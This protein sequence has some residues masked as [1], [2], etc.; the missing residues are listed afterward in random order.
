MTDF[1]PVSPDFKSTVLANLLYLSTTSA[2]GLNA[3]T[4]SV[5]QQEATSRFVSRL[6]ADGGDSAYVPTTTFYSGFFDE[7]V[8]P[9]Q[10]TIASAFLNDARGVGVLNNEVQVR[11]GGRP[12]GPFYGHAGVLFNPLTYALIVDALNNDGPGNLS[13]IDV[14]TVTVQL[15]CSAWA[16][17]G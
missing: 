3:S 10:G 6:R 16:G 9:Q 1:L 17:F 14:P 11:C 4:P 8:G 12:G 13:R 5:I 7:I 15:V 2:M